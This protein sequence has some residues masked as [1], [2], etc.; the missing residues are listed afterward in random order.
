MKSSIAAAFLILQG[1]VNIFISLFFLAIPGMIS[2]LAEEAPPSLFSFFS[3]FFGLFVVVGALQIVAGIGILTAAPWAWGFGIGVSV[4]GLFNFPVGTLLAIVCILVL[5]SSR[6]EFGAKRGTIENGGGNGNEWLLVLGTVVVVIGILW[7]LASY[8]RTPY[9]WAMAFTVIGAALM[10]L[11]ALMR[12]STRALGT[13]GE[14]FLGI[15]VFVAFFVSG[16]R[17]ENL[18]VPI[19]TGGLLLILAYYLSKR[20]REAGRFIAV[21]SI[22]AVVG[23]ACAPLYPAGGSIRIEWDSDWMDVTAREYTSQETKHFESKERVRVETTGDITVR[24]WNESKIKLQYT[25]RSSEESLLDDIRADIQENAGELRVITKTTGSREW[26]AIDYDIMVPRSNLD[27]FLMSD[28]GDIALEGVNGTLNVRTEYGDILIE[29]VNGDLRAET[30]YGD[31]EL[32]YSGGKVL[33]MGT[34]YGDV[35][36]DHSSFD[37]LSAQ[38]GYGDIE[39]DLSGI[40]N[41]TL[42]TSY[43]DVSVT[44]PEYKN[45]QVVLET[46]G[47]SIDVGIPLTVDRVS[48]NEFVGHAGSSICRIEIETTGGDI[49]IERSAKDINKDSAFFPWMRF[50]L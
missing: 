6:E 5:S 1:L 44:A 19:I 39:I 42:V 32:K 48:Q 40:G 21:L 29:K 47:G 26:E 50:S 27:L 33:N 3:I 11:G 2:Q 37:N 9:A 23:A 34:D 17:V 20:S 49:R 8:V 38:T 25:K 10:A 45:V 30:G 13:L 35:E 41:V 12:V 18:A 4:L 7:V 14:V 46:S 31:M 22:A 28:Y 15:G 24:G 43:G 16:I 36:I